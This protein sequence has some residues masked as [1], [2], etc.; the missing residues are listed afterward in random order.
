MVHALLE[1]PCF[2]LKSADVGSMAYHQIHAHVSVSV[3]ILVFFLFLIG[4]CCICIFF[5]VWM[6]WKQSYYY[7]II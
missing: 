1:H 6:T 3:Y 5:D 7:S 4:R 2:Y